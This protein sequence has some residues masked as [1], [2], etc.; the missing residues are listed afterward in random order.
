MKKP[1]FEC[2]LLFELDFVILMSM[3]SCETF[4]LW[5]ECMNGWT[6]IGVTLW[7]FIN[8][9]CCKPFG[10]YQNPIFYLMDFGFNLIYQLKC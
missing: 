7:F 9:F 4:F 1:Q 10:M 5:G 6:N 2:N 8:W 3:I